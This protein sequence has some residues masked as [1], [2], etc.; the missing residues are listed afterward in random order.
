MGNI[1]DASASTSGTVI[2]GS[3]V[4][5][6]AYIPIWYYIS[7]SKPVLL[8]AIV[9]IASAIGFYRSRQK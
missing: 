7:V 2:S 5:A 4:S 1:G 6:S 9:A 3:D 8:N